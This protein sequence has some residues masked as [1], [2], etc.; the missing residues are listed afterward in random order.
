MSRKKYLRHK[1]YKSHL[2]EFKQDTMR[3]R[4]YKYHKI[5]NI[6]LWHID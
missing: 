2:F 5:V 3:I 6:F 4:Q 1:L